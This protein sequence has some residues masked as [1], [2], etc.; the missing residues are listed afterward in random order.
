[1]TAR[2]GTGVPVR[3]RTTSTVRMDIVR[4]CV[5]TV[6]CT[7]L[8][9]LSLIVAD[10]GETIVA[11]QVVVCTAWNG[12]SVYRIFKLRQEYRDALAREVLEA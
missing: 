5:L 2:S 12:Y 7:V 8:S 6:L 4:Y 3:V 1:M 11:Y 9:I 10:D